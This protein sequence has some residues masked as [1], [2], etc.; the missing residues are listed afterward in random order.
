MGAAATISRGDL[1]VCTIRVEVV[2]LDLEEV[3]LCRSKTAAA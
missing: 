1:T 2:A 3:E